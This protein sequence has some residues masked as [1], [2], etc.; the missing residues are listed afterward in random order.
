[1]RKNSSFTPLLNSLS[2]SCNYLSECSFWREGLIYTPGRVNR[3]HRAFSAS[4]C[5][6]LHLIACCNTRR[7]LEGLIAQVCTGDVDDAKSIRAV[8]AL[9]PFSQCNKCS[10]GFLGN[11]L[12]NSVVVSY[13]VIILPTVPRAAVRPALQDGRGEVAADLLVGI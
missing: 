11:I 5:L 7:C 1:M 8:N 6:L 13:L 2:C 10:T 12:G 3:G 9:S 4:K